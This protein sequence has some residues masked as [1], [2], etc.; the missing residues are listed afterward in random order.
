MYEHPRLHVDVCIYRLDMGTE[1]KPFVRRV[2][3]LHRVTTI[4]VDCEKVYES[5]QAERAEN[6]TL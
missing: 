2:E 1:V 5:S 6:V 3:P 4:R